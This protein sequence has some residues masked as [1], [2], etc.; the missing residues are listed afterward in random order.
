[1]NFIGSIVLLLSVC[2]FVALPYGVGH[3]LAIHENKPIIIGVICGI[4][5]IAL[6]FVQKRMGN[7]GPRSH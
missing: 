4:I 3:G 2:L 7:A 6:F 5:G 1:M